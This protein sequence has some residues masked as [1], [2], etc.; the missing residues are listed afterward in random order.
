MVQN[1]GTLSTVASGLATVAYATCALTE[2][3]G[4]GVGLALSA[5]STALAGVNTYH[6]CLGGGGGCAQAAVSLGLSI[7]GTGAGIYAQ[8][9]LAGGLNMA[10]AYARDIYLARQAGVVG[11]VG[12]GLQTLIGLASISFSWGQTVSRMCQS[13]AA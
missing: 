12:D 10:N 2:G 1:A 6:A 8:N 13:N 9:A 5:T 4:C 11:A 7:V 3:I